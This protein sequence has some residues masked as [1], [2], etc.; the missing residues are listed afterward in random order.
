VRLAWRPH[1]LA[2]AVAEQHVE[3]GLLRGLHARHVVVE[4]DVRVGAA[5]R[6]A[7]QH[8]GHRLAHAPKPAND[9]R[10]LLVVPLAAVQG[11]GG[12]ARQARLLLVKG[13]VVA[14]VWVRVWVWEGPNVGGTQVR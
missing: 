6:R 12:G 4:G 2:R 5:Q 1:L 13:V 11:C 3:A 14:C 10:V 8:V 9:H 7:V